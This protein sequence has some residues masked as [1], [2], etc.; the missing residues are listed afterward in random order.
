MIAER[1]RFYRY[2]VY[3]LS[4]WKKSEKPKKL[5]GHLVKRGETTGA[6]TFGVCFH[7]IFGSLEVCIKDFQV[8][9]EGIYEQRF[10]RN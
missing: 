1:E 4:M 2:A 5:E 9:N 8:A 3:F 7:G 10:S 6:G